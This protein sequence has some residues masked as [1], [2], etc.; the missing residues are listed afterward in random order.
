MEEYL[1]GA[2]P[3]LDPNYW[4]G[5]SG[6]S[7]GGGKSSGLFGDPPVGGGLPVFGTGASPL[8]IGGSTPLLI[9]GVVGFILLVILY[10]S[11]K[12]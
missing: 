4:S 5:K 11:M 1:T 8:S 12:K 10:I 2:F 7:T 6:G 9:G 3:W